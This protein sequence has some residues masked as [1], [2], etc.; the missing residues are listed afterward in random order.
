MPLLSIS[1]NEETLFTYAFE[2]LCLIGRDPCCQLILPDKAVS[3]KHAIIFKNSCDNFVIKDLGSS[4][5]TFVN[6]ERID[7]HTL[8]PNDIITI[9]NFLIIFSQYNIGK[10]P[11]KIV[12]DGYEDPEAKV[13]VDANRYSFS[14]VLSR[15]ADIP[16]IRKLL[17]HLEIIYAISDSIARILDIPELLKSTLYHIVRVF[18]KADQ[19]FTLLYDKQTGNLEL[20]AS[21][22]K[23]GHD[24]KEISIS[25]ALIGEVIGKKQAV[26][27]TDATSD[28]RFKYSNSIMWMGIHSVLVVPLICRTEFLG[29]LYMGSFE[30][31][32]VFKEDDKEL[33]TGI[34][35]QVAVAIKNAYMHE[36]HMKQ[37]RI[38]LDLEYARRIQQS[39]LPKKVPKLQ[40]IACNR[41][42]KPAFDVGGDFYDFITIDEGKIAVIIGD[43]SGKGVS[44]ALMMAKFTSELRLAACSLKEP[45]QVLTYMNDMVNSSFQE[46]SFITV[47]YSIFDIQNYELI[48]GNAGHMPVLLTRDKK[49]Y[50]V[51][52]KMFPALGLFDDKSFSQLT[53]KLQ[54]GDRLLYF[55]DGITEMRNQH[56]EFFGIENLKEIM[57]MDLKEDETFVSHHIESKLKA[58]RG[59]SIQSDDL[60]IVEIKIVGDV[61]HQEDIINEGILKTYCK[62]C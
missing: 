16:R 7:I 31:S 52:S 28:D 35:N 22:V 40:Q 37:Q 48:Y 54:T 42:Y 41:L 59:R 13:V 44:A 27:S 18:P 19:C 50:E 46:E 25:S 29:I 9:C 33:M 11:L 45:G 8:F 32:D 24:E 23:K 60:T 58:F 34:A 55:T 10:K 56:G 43:V 61:Q 1:R 6:N 36:Y 53:W 30:M 15:E 26:L 62:R 4:N 39:F 20:K 47:F 2:E 38:N 49:V 21:Y 14:K 5:G 17:E 12:L 3:R 57:T 51:G